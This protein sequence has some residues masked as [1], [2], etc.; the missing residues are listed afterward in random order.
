MTNDLISLKKAINNLGVYET[1]EIKN[2]IDRHSIQYTKNNNGI[3]VNMEKFSDELITDIN[4]FIKFLEDNKEMLENKKKE[5]DKEKKNINVSNHNKIRTNVTVNE[6]DNKYYN[7]D[8][9]NKYEKIIYNHK[10]NSYDNNLNVDFK[11]FGTK[12]SKRYKYNGVK[13]KILKNIKEKNKKRLYSIDLMISSSIQLTNEERKNKRNSKLSR[14]KRKTSKK[15]I[16]NLEEIVENIELNDI[17]DDE[18][19]EELDD[20]ELDDEELEDDNLEED[21]LEDDE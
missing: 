3:F 4:I 1:S 20:E 2:I 19:N 12:K 21:E 5:I 6:I 15:K 13:L 18:I 11:I 8:Y 16:L 9:L 14:K 7:S 10:K 17:Q